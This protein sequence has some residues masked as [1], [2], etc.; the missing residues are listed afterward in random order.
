MKSVDSLITAL[1][2]TGV[3]QRPTAKIDL[4]TTTLSESSYGANFI[5]FT[6]SYAYNPIA[7]THLTTNHDSLTNTTALIAEN[8][9]IMEFYG[10]ERP[11]GIDPV[12]KTLIRYEGY[13]QM[14]V[15]ETGVTFKLLGNPC[16]HLYVTGDAL[17]LPSGLTVKNASHYAVGNSDYRSGT[18]FHTGWTAESWHSFRLDWILSGGTFAKAAVLFKTQPL[19]DN[20]RLLDCSVLNTTSAWISPV[21]L[22][23]VTA[24]SLEEKIGET[25]LLSFDV[26]HGSQYIHQAST[27]SYGILRPNRMLKVQTG[28][29]TGNNIA[30]YV[31]AGQFFIDTIKVKK[32][33]L[34][35]T[36][37]VTARDIRKKA[38]DTLNMLYPNIL[39]YDLAG[40]D[41][42]A[43]FNEPN[44]IQRYASY[45]SW[46]ICQTVRDLLYHA[47]VSS[48]Q[49]WATGSDGNFKIQEKDVK[50]NRGEFYKVTLPGEVKDDQLKYAFN[51]GDPLLE[52]I[53]NIVEQYGYEF[54]TDYLGDVF[55]REANNPVQYRADD[56]S[57][58]FSGVWVTGFNVKSFAGV[59]VVGSG[60]ITINPPTDFVGYDIF[61][62]RMKDGTNGSYY[63][64]WNTTSHGSASPSPYYNFW[65][66]RDG[67]DPNYGSNPSVYRMPHGLTSGTIT[68]SSSS[69]AGQ[70]LNWAGYQIYTREREAAVITFPESRVT[71]LDIENTDANIRNSVIVAGDDQGYD[72]QK[73]ITS[74]SND[75]KSMLNPQSKNYIGYRKMFILP[76]PRIV[77]QD[78]A[79]WLSLSL[80]KKYSRLA[81][82]VSYEIP[83]YP[84]LELG[85]CVAITST[86]AGLASTDEFWV[87]SIDSTIEAGKYTMNVGLNPYK[88]WPS[89]QNELE[90]S[91]VTDY[92]SNFIFYRSDGRSLIP[93]DHLANS[94]PT[95]LPSTNIA[96]T[97]YYAAHWANE[98]P[99]VYIGIGFDLWSS[100]VIDL[101]IQN[102]YT[103]ETWAIIK[104]S[105]YL[106]FGHY[107]YIW[108]GRYW[109]SDSSHYAFA[110]FNPDYTIDQWVDFYNRDD[111]TQPGVKSKFAAY[112]RPQLKYNSI[113]DTNIQGITYGENANDAAIDY[114]K[115]IFMSEDAAT[116]VDEDWISTENLPRCEVYPTEFTLAGRNG[117][118][119]KITTGPYNIKVKFEGKLDHYQF[120]TADSISVK[121]GDWV[122]IFYQKIPVESYARGRYLFRVI[123]R[124]VTPWVLQDISGEAEFLANTVT[125]IFINLEGLDVV[126]DSTFGPDRDVNQFYKQKQPGDDLKRFQ[127]ATVLAPFTIDYLGQLQKGHPGKFVNAAFYYYPDF[128]YTDGSS[129]VRVFKNLNPVRLES[130][131]YAS[132]EHSLWPMGA[133][134]LIELRHTNDSNNVQRTL[135]NGTYAPVFTCNSITNYGT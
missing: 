100:S 44:G 113:V 25:A 103:A 83:P 46:T 71:Q 108:D 112:F 107:E 23:G 99:P 3:F 73:F 127:N 59:E 57:I 20:Y 61:F 17:T 96:A 15:G 47:G 7:G 89:Y 37:T 14:P 64:K 6:G 117:I 86:G 80:L 120:V 92:I 121:D 21:T 45:D 38:T 60:S 24:I 116:T 66:Y 22:S 26:A 51:V 27:D 104:S 58:I 82:I 79:D 9:Q 43:V 101:K 95:M 4:Y 126:R 8:G 5:I 78:H 134:Y 85:D 133:D 36:Y 29:V 130:A 10:L 33:S 97:G 106:T 70:Q 98:N 11:C 39:S 42:D 132:K 31:D 28:F 2:T 114:G 63:A 18:E 76:D 123:D 93:S 32:D 88:P 16:M 69:A 68:I 119:F 110:P 62:N 74:K 91:G 48:K 131:A 40:Y 111:P 72:L 75:Y 19:N 35:Q 54:G 12:T 135:V 102:R 65:Y 125:E 49:L 50:L 109:D 129:Y 124:T 90:P 67:E 128:T 94:I 118:L 84:Q 56:N 87:D 115:V 30:T 13:F 52:I 1:S 105:R 81:D 53:N 77:Q 41:S 122:T 55:L 34:G